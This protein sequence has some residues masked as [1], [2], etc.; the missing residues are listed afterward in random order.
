MVSNTGSFKVD[1]LASL[2]RGEEDTPSTPDPLKIDSPDKRKGSAEY[3]KRKFEQAQQIILNL[4]ERSLAFEDIPD[5]LTVKK[6]KPNPKVSVRVTQVHGSMRAQDM[7]AK[8]QNIRKEKEKKAEAKN[9]REEREHERS[10]H[11]LQ[12]EVQ[13]QPKEMLCIWSKTKLNMQKCAQI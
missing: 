5:L 6:V 8:V 7:I 11:P 12:R 2:I 4:S 3:C 1:R 13:L 10:V 9:N